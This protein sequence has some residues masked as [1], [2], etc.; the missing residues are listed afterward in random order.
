[1]TTRHGLPNGGGAAGS[2]S[3]ERRLRRRQAA[4]GDGL[5]RNGE[6]EGK[7]RGK[8]VS[9][10][11][12]LTLNVLAC[13]AEAEELG[14]RRIRARTAADGGGGDGLIRANGG[15]LAH[16][17]RGGGRGEHGGDD[18]AARSVPS[19]PSRRRCAAALGSVHGHGAARSRV[20]V[21]VPMGESEGRERS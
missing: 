20:R 16:R 10:D 3:P 21:S 14:R 7:E 15:V 19:G 2:W 6:P 12:E 4:A 18:G 11:R 17:A 8:H 13:L 9:E 1:M 5:R